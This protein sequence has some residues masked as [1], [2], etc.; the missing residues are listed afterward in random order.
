MAGEHVFIVKRGGS[1]SGVFP[2]ASFRLTTFLKNEAENGVARSRRKRRLTTLCV[3]MRQTEFR[4]HIIS[5]EV[6]RK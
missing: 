6:F 3:T 1:N 4:L 5:L 2:S